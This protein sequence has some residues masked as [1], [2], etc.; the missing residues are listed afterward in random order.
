VV[1]LLISC[2]RQ[3][4]AQT[5][6]SGA[7]E[8]FNL[9]TLPKG[10]PINEK[11]TAIVGEW[12]EYNNL[13]GNVELVYVTENKEELILVIE[14]LIENQKILE[15]SEYPVVFDIPQIKSRQKVFKT[16]LLK[17]KA[18]LDDRTD[19]TVPVSEMI[20]AYNAMRSQ[21]N[22]TVNHNLDSLLILDQ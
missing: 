4:S 8:T 21:F 19:I 17:L 13:A 18:A 12:P 6:A 10:E 22:V 15:Q 16:Y 1:S 20:H 5:P 11:A 2:Q 7:R 3:P 14:E 9:D